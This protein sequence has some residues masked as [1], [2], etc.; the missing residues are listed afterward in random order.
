VV[1]VHPGP[2]F[3]FQHVT[4]DFG[5]AVFGGG[6]RESSPRTPYLPVLWKNRQNHGHRERKFRGTFYIASGLPTM[7]ELSP[8]IGTPNGFRLNCA[9]VL[10]NLALTQS[11]SK[12][13]N[14]LWNSA[15][16]DGVSYE[17]TNSNRFHKSTTAG[18]L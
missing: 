15:M 8:G 10:Q 13:A 16:F 5:F 4:G 14:I 12:C 7:R 9:V 2:P 17:H 3:S 18:F 1:Q 6:F 11:G